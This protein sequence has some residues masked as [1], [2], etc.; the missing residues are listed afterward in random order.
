[1]SA[2]RSESDAAAVPLSAAQQPAAFIEFGVRI[3]A[4]LAACLPADQEP[5]QELH[6]A[7]RYA[8]L[9][10]GKRL[11]PV[12]VYATGTA[13]GAPLCDLDAATA[14][15]EIIHAYSL[16]HDDLPAM[17]DDA[18]RRGRPTCHVVFG[19][20]MA[21]LAGDALQALA[22]DVLANAKDLLMH[23]QRIVAMI[24]IL[25][26]A[27]GAHGMAGGQAFDLA[28]VGQAL[29][30]SE[31]ERMHVYKTGALIRASIGVGAR[32]AGCDD[33]QLLG[34]L[35]RYGH[36]IGLAFQI[37]DDILDVE[38][39]AATV[40]KTIGKDAASNK[41]TYPTIL[42]MQAARAELD[43]VTAA[44]IDALAPYADRFATLRDI[45]IYIARRSA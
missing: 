20:A 12:L 43:R 42:G 29:D 8:L 45:A 15:V 37:R 1:M 41:P 16:V 13:L 44:A 17:D 25:A 31:L 6:R 9:G 39:D 18:V 7:M 27:C 21:I 24:Q 36:F 11:R 10:G 5:P 2:L 33:T 23:P 35:D 30:A 40:G 32:A 28:A 4:V 34:A 19:E 3:E 22:F 14:A 38:G 26:A